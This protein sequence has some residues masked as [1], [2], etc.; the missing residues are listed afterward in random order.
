MKNWDI[1]KLIGELEMMA[2]SAEP[3]MVITEEMSI[4]C[5]MTLQRAVSELKSK[6]NDR[7]IAYSTNPQ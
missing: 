6:D 3:G 2:L 4:S 7:D 1:K 5:S